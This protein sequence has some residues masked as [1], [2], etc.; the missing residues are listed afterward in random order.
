MANLSL[1]GVRVNKKIR[2]E[3]DAFIAKVSEKIKI[4]K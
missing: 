2:A 1:K 3:S 4:N